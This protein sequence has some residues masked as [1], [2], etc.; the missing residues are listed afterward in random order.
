[1]KALKRCER[2]SG[3]PASGFTLIELLVVIAV[4]SILA[5]L[6][7][8][9]TGAVNRAKV[10]SKARAE[11]EQVQ[12]A[13]ETYKSKLGH[14]PPDTPNSPA[15]NQLYYELLGTRLTN[16]PNGVVYTTLDGSARI[17]Q[18]SLPIIFK[19]VDGFVN[20]SRPSAGDEVKS[21]Q[22][23]LK[24]LKPDRIVTV[25]NG[26]D[27]VSFL[28]CSV[29]WPSDSTHPSFFGIRN[30]TANPFRYNSSN[31]TNNPA[32]FDLWVDVVIAGKTNRI[33]NWSREALT[34]FA[35]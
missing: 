33:C 3:R 9:I 30:G 26:T 32:S 19:G 10:K 4:I 5:A 25:T 27:A 35:P 12:T 34:V 28:V 17:R 31:P 24:G 29:P 16:T 1:M 21:A 15:T 11:L 13:I 23:F 2:A 6:V 14:Y 8:P 7:I 22:V 18:S 20:A